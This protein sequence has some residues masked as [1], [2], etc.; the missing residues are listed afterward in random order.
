MFQVQYYPEL[1]GYIS[2]SSDG[3]R[4]LAIGD[5]ERR[6]VRYLR[7]QRGIKCFDFCK[8]PSFLVTGGRDKVIR[9]WNPYVLSKPAGS[10]TGHNT[11]ISRIVM[12]HEMSYIISLSE[13]KVVKVWSART[14]QCLQTIVDK[15]YHRPENDITSLYYDNFNRKMIFGH[16]QLEVFIPHRRAK[17]S[18]AVSHEAT[19]VAAM[20]NESFHQVVSGCLNSSVRVWNLG[21]GEKTFQ[22]NDVHGDLEITAMSFDKTHRRL[23]TGSRD[24]VIRLWNFNNGQMLQQMQTES[25]LE[26][27]QIKYVETMSNKLIICVGWDQRIT[28]FADD[29][30]NYASEPQRQLIASASLNHSGRGHTD[31]I[32]CVDFCPP[33]TL[34]TG[35]LDGNLA[36]WNADSGHCRMVLRE[37]FHHLRSQVE[38]GVEKVIFVFLKPN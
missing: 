37:P 30:G 6:T 1:N 31:D 20:Y 16:D 34:V 27:T 8:R 13:D 18:I 17:L 15:G 29:P 5:I 32:L 25:K 33:N 14:L 24:G 11:S 23:L 9:L 7:V 36:V 2:C 28:F 10:L 3:A 4:S 26:I 35:G 12:N 22:Y 21:T 19:V 38:R